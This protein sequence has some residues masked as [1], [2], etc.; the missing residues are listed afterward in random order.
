MIRKASRAAVGTHVRIEHGQE[1]REQRS[2][3]SG[4]GDAPDVRIVHI[5]YVPGS[6]DGLQLPHEPGLIVRQSAV[7]VD[8]ESHLTNQR[9]L[10]KHQK[11]GWRDTGRTPRAIRAVGTGWTLRAR[12]SLRTLGT[13]CTL[14]PEIGRASCR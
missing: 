10:T 9:P 11:S 8:I 6:R 1:S 2:V 12:G 4:A 3:G 7:P 14:R 13:Y 5:V